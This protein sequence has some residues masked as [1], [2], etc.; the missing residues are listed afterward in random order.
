MINYLDDNIKDRRLW[1]K[2]LKSWILVMKNYIDNSKDLPYWHDERANTGFLAAAVWMLGGV[3][4]EE[5]WTDRIYHKKKSYVGRCDLWAKLGSLTFS[6]EAKQLWS[7]KS[8]A[9]VEDI[10]K[11]TQ[12]ELKSVQ[13]PD[14]GKYLVSICFIS[15]K[16]GSNSKFNKQEIIELERKLTKQ[17]G[18]IIATFF[19]RGGKQVMYKGD[20]YPCVIL[21]AKVVKAKAKL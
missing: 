18:I 14:K 19:P 12:K 1:E 13:S 3:A 9:R 16:I 5:Y 20:Q 17:K 2:L 21:I 4:I 6:A 7:A 8:A 15:P 10:I 11:R